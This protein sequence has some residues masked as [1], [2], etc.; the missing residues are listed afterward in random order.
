LESSVYSTDDSASSSADATPFEGFAALDCAADCA[1]QA[2]RESAID[3]RYD[4]PRRSQARRINALQ[5]K[6]D[7]AQPGLTDSAA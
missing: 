5:S 2:D 7:T 1:K 3:G 6:P 4:D